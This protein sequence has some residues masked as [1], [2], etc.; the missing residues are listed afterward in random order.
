[1]NNSIIQRHTAGLYSEYA[2]D[3]VIG[4]HF[5]YDKRLEAFVAELDRLGLLLKSFKWDEWYNNS[6]MVD[7]PEYI[8][9][10]GMYECQLLIT[11]MSRLD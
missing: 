8:A 11:A 6:Y 4:N 9:D 2:K 1:M 5:V 3:L 7:R 10:A